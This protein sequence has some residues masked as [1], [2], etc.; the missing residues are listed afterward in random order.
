MC[1]ISAGIRGQISTTRTRWLH[2][3]VAHRELRAARKIHARR[4]VFALAR[5][6]Q[7][8]SVRCDASDLWTGVISHAYRSAKQFRGCEHGGARQREAL[9]RCA[10]LHER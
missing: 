5:A 4:T 2:S 3:R 6:T 9:P 1:N 10:A 7:L 8:L